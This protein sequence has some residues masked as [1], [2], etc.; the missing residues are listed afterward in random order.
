MRA[1]SLVTGKY[2]MTSTGIVHGVASGSCAPSGGA[3][4]TRRARTR[5]ERGMGA[6]TAPWGIACEGFSTH[7]LHGRGPPHRC[8]R[9]SSSKRDLL[10][11]ARDGKLLMTTSS[12]RD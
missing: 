4:E 10:G 1:P 11:L 8:A 9:R 7:L 5:R 12:R 6:P 2:L 3:V